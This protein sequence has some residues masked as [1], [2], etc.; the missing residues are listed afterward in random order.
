MTA[1]MMRPYR[2]HLVKGRR[3]FAPKKI[4]LGELSEGSVGVN[5]SFDDVSVDS[6]LKRVQETTEKLHLSPRRPSIMQ[7]RQTYME[8][9]DSPMLRTALNGDASDER[10]TADQKE[11]INSALDWLRNELQ[12]MRSEDQTLARQL[13]SIRQD[14]H[15]VIS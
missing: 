1:A 10:L 7:W 11:R 4:S 8:S 5:D 3:L 13:L 9:P 14:L 15:K 6:D 2:I 12:E